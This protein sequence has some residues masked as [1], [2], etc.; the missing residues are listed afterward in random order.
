MLENFPEDLQIEISRYLNVSEIL[1]LSAT[2]RYFQ[3]HYHAFGL[4]G[5]SYV[6]MILFKSFFHVRSLNSMKIL[7]NSIARNTYFSCLPEWIRT[8]AL[9]WYFTQVLVASVN[10]MKVKDQKIIDGTTEYK[11]YH[12]FI[13]HFFSMDLPESCLEVQEIG[14]SYSDANRVIT[15]ACRLAHVRFVTRYP[16]YD[17]LG[18]LLRPEIVFRGAMHGAQ[19]QLKINRMFLLKY[20]GLDIPDEHTPSN[21]RPCDPFC[22][23]CETKSHAQN[24]VFPHFVG[25]DYGT[26]V[27]KVGYEKL[28]FD[29][30]YCC[31]FVSFFIMHDKRKASP[32]GECFPMNGHHRQHGCMDFKGKVKKPGHDSLRSVVA[33][34][35]AHHHPCLT[36]LSL[37]NTLLNE[38]EFENFDTLVVFN[39][40]ENP[41]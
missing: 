32:R 2:N 18:N 41:Q 27:K 13:P 30:D 35:F 34:S 14:D 19:L 25:I 33:E 23:T 29:F 8:N 17:C 26:R 20:M 37:A 7:N 28:P 24:S 36:S 12:C 15:E 40:E 16:Q 5:K 9:S 3:S 11:N 22:D 10:C 38:R 31:A 4:E 39:D 21:N 1:A 6:A